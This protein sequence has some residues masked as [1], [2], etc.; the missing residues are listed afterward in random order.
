MRFVLTA[1]LW[2]LTTVMLAVAVPAVWAQQHL[3]SEQGYAELAASA[4]TEPRLQDA[5]ADEL[6]TQITALTAD[7]GYTLNQT[8]VHQVASGYTG[9]AGFPGQFAQANRIAHRWMFTDD[10]PHASADDQWLIDIAPM[11]SDPSLMATLGNLELDVPETL[12]VPVTVPSPELRPGRLQALATWGPWAAIG[13]AVLTGLLALLTLAGSRRRGKGLAALGVS[14]LLVGAGGWA[15]LEVA[16][17]H[18]DDALTRV[19]GNF[20]RIVDEMVIHA[21]DSLHHWLN[22]TLIAGVALVVTGVVVSMLGGLRR[23]E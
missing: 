2:L 17:R 22:M 6:T 21:E 12:M 4:A 11:L 3:V 15:G 19:E 10:F 20:R 7:R 1:L 23:P 9:N 16:N 8:L 13:A 5:M 18:V 14:A